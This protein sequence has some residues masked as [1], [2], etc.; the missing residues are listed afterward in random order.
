MKMRTNLKG[1]KKF[2]WR[3][4]LNGFFVCD[5]RK[6]TDSEVRKVVEYGISKGYETEADI[7][8]SEVEQLLNAV[9]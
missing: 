4:N 5:G 6:L 8:E 7:P 1:V 2:I 9:E 3:R